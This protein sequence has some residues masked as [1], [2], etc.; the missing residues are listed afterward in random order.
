ERM[1][2]RLLCEDI[3]L[4]TRL[5][6]SLGLV[7]ADPVHIH[8]V[9]I[10]LAVNARDAMPNGGTLVIETANTP[11][12]TRKASAQSEFRAS[13]AVRLSVTDTGMGM[14]EETRKNISEPFYTTKGN[15]G[16]GLGL[17]T[18]YGIIQQN[19]GWIEV[20]S[21]LGKGSVFRVY[22]PRTEGTEKPAFAEPSV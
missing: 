17:A 21:D 20:S 7:T 3:E 10:N 18:V 12:D 11:L 9:L 8:Q 14:D 16:S 4:I 13:S 15:K 22:L 6:P 2:R 1:L 5:D 19:Q